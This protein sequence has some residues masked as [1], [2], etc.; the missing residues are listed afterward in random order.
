[1]MFPYYIYFTN[2]PINSIEYFY[3]MNLRIVSVLHFD[4]FFKCWISELLSES[5]LLFCDIHIEKFKFRLI[6]QIQI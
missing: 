1:M 2:V 4:I 5:D 3:S 6:I